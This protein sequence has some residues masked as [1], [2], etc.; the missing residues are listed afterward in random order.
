MQMYIYFRSIVLNNQFALCKVGSLCIVSLERQKKIGLAQ[1]PNPH[2]EKRQQ[3][4]K[5]KQLFNSKLSY[6]VLK[7]RSMLSLTLWRKKQ[8]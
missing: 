3:V 6:F 2:R 4:Q 5:R 8:I 7:S 1:R